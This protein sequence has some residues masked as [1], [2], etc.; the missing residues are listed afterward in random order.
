MFSSIEETVRFVRDAK[1]EM[2]D[3]KLVD[4]VGRWYHVTVPVSNFSKEIMT[5]GIGIDA[6]SYIGYRKVHEGDMKMIPDYTSCFLDPFAELKTLSIVCDIVE[7]DGAHYNRCP[8][9]VAKRAVE[10]MATIQKGKAQFGLEIECYIFNDMRYASEINQAFYH[11]DSAEA[12]WNTGKG[13]SPNQGN[14]FRQGRGYHGT[15]PA[16]RTYNIRSQMVKLVEG[17]GVPV[18]YHHHEVGGPCQVEI[19]IKHDSLVKAADAV[20]KV[21]YIIK[22]VAFQNG[23]VATFMPKPLYQEGGNA[24]HV[25]QS[26]SDNGK[27]LFYDRKGYAGLS[28]TALYY[29][30]GLLTHGRALCAMTN[31]STNSYKRLVPGYEAPTNL[32]FA[33]SNRTAGVRIPGFDKSPK[34]TR[35]EYRPPDSTGNA[36]LSLAAQLMAGLDGIENKI[37]ATEQG[38]GPYDVDITELSEEERAK[39]GELPTSLQYAL[40][41]L[42]DDYDFLL[43]GEVF[44][45]D[46]VK[47]WI[48]HKRKFDV[49]PLQLR[50]HPYEFT[51]YH[52]V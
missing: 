44:N 50:P 34:G 46:L 9:N 23:M 20:L 6:S 8:R 52:D 12:F 51:M 47:T 48:A 28:Q 36:Y 37:D 25:H 4:L 26:I 17:I 14:K 40:D 38:F 7:R 24:G 27:S 41:A 49:L 2:V 35:V 31:P 21:K 16:D 1:V 19:T 30:G 10:Y 29:I 39:I 45:E 33:T 22:N 32:C 3:F 13:D 11:V 5:G 15:P 42:A 18:Q 43:K